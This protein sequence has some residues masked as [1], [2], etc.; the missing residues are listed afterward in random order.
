MPFLKVALFFLLLAALT[1]PIGL[2]MRR[3]FSGE[4]TFLEPVLRPVERLL[5]PALRAS[6]R[7]ANSH[8][9]PTPWPCSSSA[10]PVSSSTYAIQRL[11]HVLP[12]NPDKLGAVAAELAWNTAV[13]FT[14]NTNWQAYVGE[15]TMSHLT[16]MVGAGVPQLRLRR[17]RNGH[18]HRRHPRSRARQSCATPR[19]LLGRSG[20]RHALDPA[21]AL[22]GHRDRARSRRASCRT[23]TPTQEVTTLDGAEQKIAQ[24]PVASQ[25]AIKELGTNGGGFFNANSAHPYENPTPFTNLLQMFLDP[26]DRGGPDLHA[27]LDDRQTAARLGGLRGDVDPL[28]RA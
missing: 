26:L 21:A 2:Y 1:K 11:Q 16:Q 14:T 5:Y 22:A 19:Q 20:A 18:R 9:R 8:G 28:P 12:L 24:G 23:S 10:W 17:Y 13:S 7:S 4:R 27:R 15:A 3:V 6:T 25:E